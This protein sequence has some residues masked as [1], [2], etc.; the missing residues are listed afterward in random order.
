MKRAPVGIEVGEIEAAKLGAAQAGRV[1]EFE[2]GPV[3]QTQRVAHVGDGQQFFNSGQGEHILGQALLGP[4]Q[5]QLA[6][7]VVDDHVLPGDPPE[8]ILEDAQAVALACS[9]PGVGHWGEC[10]ARAT[11]GRSPGSGV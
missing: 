5:L 1:K 8:K 3:A 7:G 4:G 11:A 9:S 6:G 2:H 10:N